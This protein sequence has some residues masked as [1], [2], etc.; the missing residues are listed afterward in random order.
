MYGTQGV[1]KRCRL[2][3]LTN[4][5]LPR[6]SPNAGEGG[7]LKGSQPMSTAVHK[8]PNKLWR[9]NS[10]LNLCKYKNLAYLHIQEFLYTTSSD[11]GTLK[12]LTEI[13]APLE[14]FFHPNKTKNSKKNLAKFFFHS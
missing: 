14:Q 10:I 3:W 2:S 1:T 5:A 9:S 7:E 11:D 8:S 6:I 13:E 12:K 4:S